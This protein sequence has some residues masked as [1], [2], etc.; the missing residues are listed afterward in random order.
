MRVA[1]PLLS[2]ALAACAPL[3][4]ASPEPAEVSRGPVIASSSL[5]PMLHFPVRAAAAPD[6]SNAEMARDFL[7]LSFSLESGRALPVFTRFEGP[8]TLRLAGTPPPTMERDLA[9]L[10]A[11]LRAEAGIDITRTDGPE[12]SITVEAVPRDTLAAAVP[13]AA[14]FVVPRVTSWAAFTQNR[15]GPALDWTT[16]TTRTHAA[17]FIPAD[18][19]PQEVRTCL[20]E[21]LAQALGP[22]NDLYRLPDSTFND[23]DIHVV[24]T[25]FDMLM[26][27]ATY[28]P[29]LR[30]GLSRAEVAARLPAI[31]ARLNPAGERAGGALL[32]ATPPGWAA[33]IESALA[34]AASPAARRRAAREAVREADAAG[35][36]PPE[37]GFARYA[38]GRLELGTDADAANLAFREAARIFAEAGM[39]LHAAHVTLQLAGQA[40]ASGDAEAVLRLTTPAIAAA[41]RGENAALLALLMAEKAAALRLLGRTEEAEA[42]TV[43]TIGWARY[44]YGADSTVRARLSEIEGL[45]PAVSG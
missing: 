1:G 22:L 39:P 25:G 33:Q 4:G 28:A 35:L 32:P 43:D 29:E 40:L 26:L 13:G 3:P 11:R 10:L 19:A 17:V 38:L 2:L 42:L 30:S 6:R 34:S 37:R 31:L 44:G 20:H 15:R 41:E 27:R 12:A 8:V 18:A 14:C 5:P 9:E 21:E 36:G 45:S 23:D 16:L 24:L 7:D